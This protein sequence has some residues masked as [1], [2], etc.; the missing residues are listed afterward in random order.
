MGPRIEFRIPISPTP[1]FYERVHL[2]C[3]ALR[4]AEPCSTD[5]VKIVVGD[6]AD[7]SQVERDNPWSSQY[8]VE[9]HRVPDEIVAAHSYYGTADFRYLLPETKS[10]LVVL[11]DADTVLLRPIRQDFLWMIRPEPCVAGHM[12][13]MAPWFEPVVGSELG[14]E[15]LWPFLFRKFSIPWPETLY[16]YSLDPEG[17][18]TAPA[19]YNLGFVVL[20]QAALRIFRQEIFTVQEQL[21]KFIDSYM[22]CQIA[23]TLISYRHAMRRTNLPAV[24]NTANDLA[25][26]SG[27]RVQVD[28]IKVLHYLRND[29]FDKRSFLTDQRSKFLAATLEN[30]ANQLLQEVIRELQ[31]QRLLLAD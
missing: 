27:N 2:F 10:D 4:R 19:Y 8:D 17:N 31:T 15:D 3:A 1:D 29:E 25:H 21:R 9:W 13:H 20:N 23:V 6:G 12:A 16:R 24:F 5:V 18:T 28:Q 7:L 14:S 11:S 22:R 26:L 30:P